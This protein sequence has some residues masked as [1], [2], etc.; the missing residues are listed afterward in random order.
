MSR[1]QGISFPDVNDIS[2]R[3]LAVL[4][5]HQ[6]QLHPLWGHYMRVLVASGVLA[7]WL[8]ASQSSH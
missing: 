7:Q 6:E 4:S 3:L 8:G 1:T 5:L 2:L